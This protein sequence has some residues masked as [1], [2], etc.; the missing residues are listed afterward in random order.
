MLACCWAAG[1]LG[2]AQRRS[3]RGSSAASG[4]QLGC[5]KPP[6]LLAALQDPAGAELLA[7]LAR[8]LACLAAETMDC[9]KKVENGEPGQGGGIPFVL[10]GRWG[11][12]RFSPLP[13]FAG[14]TLLSLSLITRPPSPLP[15]RLPLNALARAPITGVISLAAMGIGVGDEATQEASAAAATATQLLDALLPALLSAFG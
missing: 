6:R 4:L 13:P 8:L 5:S 7:K 15:F 11:A 9:L 1:L 10:Q 12:V 14:L 3:Q 2:C